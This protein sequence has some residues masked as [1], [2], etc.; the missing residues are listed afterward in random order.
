MV[1]ALTPFQSLRRLARTLDQ[2]DFYMSIEDDPE[3]GRGKLVTGTAP[4]FALNAAKLR[5]EGDFPQTVKGGAAML[6]HVQRRHR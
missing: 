1:C 2:W 4:P 3:I 6:E 5:R